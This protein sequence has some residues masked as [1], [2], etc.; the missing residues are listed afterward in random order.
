MPLLP[1]DPRGHSMDAGRAHR[2]LELA[3]RTGLTLAACKAAHDE[4][5]GDL[6]RAV[7]LLRERYVPWYTPVDWVSKEDAA[8]GQ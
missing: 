8:S 3:Q 5:G 7:A 4:A 6:D 1:N 2:I